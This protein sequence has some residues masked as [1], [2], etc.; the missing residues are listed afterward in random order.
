MNPQLPSRPASSSLTAAPAA[1]WQRPDA[2]RAA[3]SAGLPAAMADGGTLDV[4]RYL[5]VLGQR[6]RLVAAVAAVVVAGT[7]A[8]TL[9][10]TPI[11]RAT[12]VL[13][14][15]GQTADVGT[16]EAL[17]QG[18][19]IPT[20]YLETQY[21]V[22]R[23]AALSRLVIADV[24]RPLAEE[25]GEAGEEG[26]SGARTLL[27]RAAPAVTDR[28]TDA[29]AER[30]FVDPVVGSNLVKV[31]YESPD[32]ALAARV[33]ASM[34]ESYARLQSDVGL[35][36]VTR[37]AAQVDST[38]ARL[39]LDEQ[40]LQSFA[41]QHG[42]DMVDGEEG[43]AESLPQERLRTLQRQLTEAEAERYAR[44]SL[45]TM[46]RPQSADALDSEV[47]R[48]L[49]VRLAALSGEY[50][51]LRSTF[52]ADY[53]KAREVKDQI[54]AQQALLARERARIRGQRADEFRM[55]V[56]RQALLQAAVD[57]QRAL[58]DRQGESS[59]RYRILAR[60]AEAQRQ[61]YAMLREK[62]QG[63][64]VSAAMAAAH[65]SVIEP[66]TVPS[67][68]ARP[69]LAANLLL[70]AL[71]G[72]ALGVGLAFYREYA[73]GTLRSVEDVDAL[74]VP[75]L[76]IIPSVA[77]GHGPG[78]ADDP[79]SAYTLGDDR[80]ILARVATSPR[81]R[82]LHAGDGADDP[83]L[84]IDRGPAGGAHASWLDDAFASLRTS[85]LLDDAGGAG[86]RSL[87]VTSAQPGDGKTMTCV[88]LALSLAKLGRRV[89]LVDADTRRPAVHQAL[90]IPP[91]PGLTEALRGE[92]GWLSLVHAEVAP[93]LDV[94][95]A[96]EA[97]R[98]PVELLS[99]REMA[100]LIDEAEARYDFVLLDTPALLINAADTRI[101][102]ALVDGVIVV[103]RSGSTPRTALDRMLGHVPNLVGVVLNRLDV[104][105]FSPSYYAYGAADERAPDRD[106]AGVAP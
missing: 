95:P 34:F 17:F 72:L 5:R 49:D 75:L 37:L 86:R 40:R 74:A 55:A 80:S 32:P 16:V 85:V 104:R 78:S 22:L 96:G 36:A 48:I 41:Q 20:Q 69:I 27:P 73:D 52:S 84:T 43:T 33:V 90:A 61:L 59:T 12:G 39:A 98:S 9:L 23:S 66:P 24:G 29:F 101:L 19:R 70:G 3:L 7:L 102:A 57:S 77:R 54:D 64:R 56:R 65:V 91:G 68:P 44:Q 47:L 88:N 58:V 51:R 103:I 46:Q 106:T 18:D 14:L 2:P 8:G 25:L 87:L 38:R 21:G 6:W 89:L 83:V 97:V 35:A 63:A 11:Y 10:Q 1:P 45:V 30:R 99:S 105:Q 31:H 15:R 50:A 76:G 82:M 26:A 92:A 53:P 42:L 67:D 100:A 93:G 94:L 60:D 71:V 62:L 79:E 4:H 28:Q 81:W 13:E